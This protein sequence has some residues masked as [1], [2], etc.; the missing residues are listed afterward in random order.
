MK[1]NV[2]GR[3]GVSGVPF[4]LLL[5]GKKNVEARTNGPIR[6]FY[7][8]GR[9]DWEGFLHWQHYGLEIGESVFEIPVAALDA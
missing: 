3:F 5:P 6:G 9:S 8:L 1:S 2:S 7:D 4:M